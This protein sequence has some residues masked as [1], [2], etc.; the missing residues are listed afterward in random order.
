MPFAAVGAAV[1]G[2][3]ASAA[4]GAGISA[5]TAKGQSGAISSGQAEA[6]AALAP[7]SATGVQSNTQQSNLLGLNGQDAADKAMGTFQSSPGYDY[8]VQQGIRGVDAGAA[9]QGMLHSG[10][11]LK[12]EETLGA[13]LANQN[14]QQY[15]NNLNSL[16]NFGITA[17]GG[18]ASTDTSAAGAQAGIIGAEGKNVSTA[19]GGGIT[20][21]LTGLGTNNPTVNTPSNQ[22]ALNNALTFS[23][24]VADAGY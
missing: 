10:A 2:G 1:A 13:N 22:A 14:F 19:I 15:Y 20:N 11:T 21:A 24:G 12:A 18:Q 8:Q 17:A 9:S 3:V 4:V 16:S 23:P 7:Y 5:L 6:N